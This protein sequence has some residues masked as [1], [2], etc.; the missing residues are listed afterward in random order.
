[1]GHN[2]HSNLVN[3]VILTMILKIEVYF[4][5]FCN[6]LLLYT[7]PNGFAFF[8][9]KARVLFL[10]IYRVSEIPMFGDSNES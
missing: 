4:L 1:M 8:V 6:I 10:D 2:I 7:L 9:P 5:Y 3:N